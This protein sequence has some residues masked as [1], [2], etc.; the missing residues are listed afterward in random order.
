[1]E[2]LSEQFLSDSDSFK[3]LSSEEKIQRK[4]K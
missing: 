4:I 3:T 1:M 2:D